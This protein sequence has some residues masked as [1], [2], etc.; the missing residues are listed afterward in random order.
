MAKVC[1]YYQP[2]DIDTF[3]GN[4]ERLYAWSYAFQSVGDITD[5]KII[6]SVGISYPTGI[7]SSIKTEVIKDFP[8]FGNETVTQLV[9]PWNQPPKESISL[10]NF[11]HDT[12][13]YFFGPAS[14]WKEEEYIG[15]NYVHIPTHGNTEFH[16]LHV[17]TVV[18]THRYKTLNV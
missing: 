1:I 4:P 5:L 18:M 12:D 6:D 11:D 3:S 16:S 8:D 14:G 9:C 13:W 10:W 15:D 2:Y 17:G 7:S